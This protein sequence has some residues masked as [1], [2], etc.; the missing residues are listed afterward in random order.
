MQTVADAMVRRPKTLPAAATIADARA[1]FGD[2]VHLLLIVDDAGMLLGTVVREDVEG[3]A[4]ADALLPFSTLEGRTVEASEPLVEVR[5]RMDASRRR[6]AV[7]D[8]GRLVGL[9]CLKRGLT[10]F[11][12]DEGIAER[13]RERESAAHI[14]WAGWTPPTSPGPWR[15]G[16]GTS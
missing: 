13:A 3:A 8:E 14:S 16:P 2:H 6:V 4:G 7:V 10:G 15:P 1:A 12:T 9:L 5:A 11:C